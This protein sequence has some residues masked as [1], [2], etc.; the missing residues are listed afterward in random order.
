LL[1]EQTP[2]PSGCTCDQPPNWRTEEL[3]LDCLEEIVIH[4]MRGSDLEVAL[5]LRLFHWA[6]VL[7]RMKIIFH[8]SITESKD[9]ELRQLFLSFSSLDTSMDFSTFVP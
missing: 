5:V 8:E 4:G 1:Q 7:K 6:K 9:K 2:C 3:A